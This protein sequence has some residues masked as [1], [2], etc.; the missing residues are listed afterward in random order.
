VPKPSKPMPPPGLGKGLSGGWH[1]FKLTIDWLLAILGAIA[2]FVAVL[3]IVAYGGWR[4][5]RR[6][7]RPAVPPAPQPEPPAGT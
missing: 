5:R 1:A 6:V 2:P 3:A 7:T 4:L